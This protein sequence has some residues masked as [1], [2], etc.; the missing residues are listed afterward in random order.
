MSQSFFTRFFG[1]RAVL[2]FGFDQPISSSVTSVLIDWA[3]ACSF[4]NLICDQVVDIIF[5]EVCGLDF[6]QHCI[7][8]QGS[9]NN[10][11]R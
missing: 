3:E 8:V 9:L 6:K 1:I 4:A 2:K 11:S 5:A 7:R 10:G